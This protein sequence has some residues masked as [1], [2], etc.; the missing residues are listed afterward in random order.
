MNDT[1]GAA[2]ERGDTTMAKVVHFEV[3][4]KDGKRLRDFYTSLFG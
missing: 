4:G 2:P 3:H 1:H